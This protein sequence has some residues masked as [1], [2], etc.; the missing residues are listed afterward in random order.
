MDARTEIEIPSCHR[1]KTKR[2]EGRGVEKI[3]GWCL[4]TFAYKNLIDADPLFGHFYI[5]AT[6]FPRIFDVTLSFSRNPPTPWSCT[7]S[8]AAHRQQFLLSRK[9][10]GKTWLTIF[11]FTPLPFS[12]NSVL[13]KNE[14]TYIYTHTLSW[15]SFEGSFVELIEIGRTRSFLSP[16]KVGE[17]TGFEGRDCQWISLSNAVSGLFEIWI[18]RK[19]NFLS[20]LRILL[21]LLSTSWS[22]VRRKGILAEQIPN[23]FNLFQTSFSSH[24]I[25]ITRERNFLSSMDFLSFS[26]LSTSV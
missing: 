21:S 15:L 16:H 8:L 17:G 24:W 7:R 6:S 9:R 13:T 18:I 19:R 10:T 12:S 25:R 11:T 5:K 2:R 26:L 3:Q 4:S 1:E 20:F 22:F 14:D 23:K